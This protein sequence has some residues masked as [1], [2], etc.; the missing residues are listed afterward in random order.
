MI[1][2]SDVKIVLNSELDAALRVELIENASTIL[3]MLRGTNPLDRG[4]GLVS[5]EI[6]GRNVY[7]ARAAYT[8]Q[9]IEQIEQYEPRLEVME[10]EFESAENKLIPKVVL[11]Y[12]GNGYQ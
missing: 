7:T 1:S 3:T 5:G 6:V 12:N 8:V 2:I 9:A 11:T 10:I 4:M